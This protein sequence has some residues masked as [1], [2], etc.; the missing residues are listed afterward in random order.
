M[1][2]KK[3]KTPLLI[4]GWLVAIGLTIV[5][6]YHPVRFFGF[7]IKEG[8]NN[9]QRI[10]RLL[11]KTDH[12]VLL[13]ACRNLSREMDIDDSLPRSR[14]FVRHEPSPEIKYFPQMILDIEPLCIDIYSDGRVKLEMTGALHHSGVI[15]YPENYEKPSDDFE[16]GD[17][18][19]INGLWY[20]EDHYKPKRDDKRIESLLEKG[21]RKREK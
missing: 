15:A 5:F 19:I 14:Y 2:S 18:K 10:V 9:R 3:W 13:E 21:K 11:S 17:K 8:L 1:K 16:L 12:H 6:F 4:I 7:I 20:Y